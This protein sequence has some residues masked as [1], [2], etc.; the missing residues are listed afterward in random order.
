MITS[1][2]IYRVTVNEANNPTY[3]HSGV[4]RIELFGKY[5]REANFRNAG[6]VGVRL[7]FNP[8]DRT[9]EQQAGTF[10]T[11]RMLN[12]FEGQKRVICLPV[13][14]AELDAVA[15]SLHGL[16][17]SALSEAQQIAACKVGI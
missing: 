7:S 13:S 9:W 3:L 5:M 6:N 14:E 11:V 1:S 15:N 12:I 10:E 17:W 16:E 2:G 8:P 4:Y